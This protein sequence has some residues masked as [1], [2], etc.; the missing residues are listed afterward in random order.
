[1][2]NPHCQH[3]SARLVLLLHVDVVESDKVVFGNYLCPL[4]T[5]ATTWSTWL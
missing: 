2:P 5:L 3:C 1:M 4:V